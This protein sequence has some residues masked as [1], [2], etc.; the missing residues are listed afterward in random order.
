MESRRLLLVLGETR[1]KEAFSA[2]LLEEQAV[3]YCAT[4]YHTLFIPLTDYLLFLHLTLLLPKNFVLKICL[5]IWAVG[6]T[7]MTALRPVVVLVFMSRFE[8]SDI[9][10]FAD[11]SV[12]SQLSFRK[13]SNSSAEK[14]EKLT[15][16]DGGWVGEEMVTQ[17][18]IFSLKSHYSRKVDS[19][20]VVK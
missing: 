18:L 14:P 6:M 10:F 3:Q 2:H 16:I 8:T 12:I 15:F 17:S 4:K 20:F 7:T 11:L 1:L 9:A 13:L 5:R 19:C